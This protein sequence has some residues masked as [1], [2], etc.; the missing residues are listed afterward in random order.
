MSK[1]ISLQKP[2]ITFPSGRKDTQTIKSTRMTKEEAARKIAKMHERDS[3]MVSGIFKNLEAPSKDGGS[4]LVA[5]SFRMYPQDPIEVYELRDGERYTLPR[6]VARHLNN[7]CYTL[8]YQQIDRS[9]QGAI[10]ADGR[11]TSDMNVSKKVHR[12]AFLSLEYSD[13]DIDMYPTD[14]V[15]VKSKI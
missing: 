3:E 9:I 1:S 10:S 14:L 15:E 6:G 12:F 8:E 2:A 13:D 7:G 11:K 5:F 4:G